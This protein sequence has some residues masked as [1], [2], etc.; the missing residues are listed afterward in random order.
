VTP[1]DHATAL[2][3]HGLLTILKKMKI[4]KVKPVMDRVFV[5]QDQPK[6]QGGA[7][8]PVLVTVVQMK[9]VLKNM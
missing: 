3:R 1:K 5:E 4:E 8:P 9:Q 2:D 7:V 6:N